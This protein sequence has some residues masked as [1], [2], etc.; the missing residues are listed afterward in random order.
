MLEKAMGCHIWFE[1]VNQ[2]RPNVFANEATLNVGCL[3]KVIVLIFP[4]IPKNLG[5]Y[6]MFIAVMK[7]NHARL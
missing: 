2:K 6:L 1:I 4:D 7:S 3:Q 5:R